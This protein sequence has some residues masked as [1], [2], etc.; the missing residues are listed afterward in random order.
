M[1]LRGVTRG[2]LAG[3]LIR[4]ASRLRFPYLFLLTA[5]LFVLNL[6]IPDAIPMADELIMGLVAVLLGSLRKR[7]TDDEQPSGPPDTEQ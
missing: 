3:I 5:A 1:S 6:F 4:W 7:S 2:G